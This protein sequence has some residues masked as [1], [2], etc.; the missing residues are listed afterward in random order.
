M[1]SK[2]ERATYICLIT[3]LIVAL[4]IVV[5][6]TLRHR[7]LSGAA[8]TGAELTGQHL[9]V[10]GLTWK[11]SALN[12]VLFVSPKCRFCEESTPFYRKITS[13]SAN[14]TKR[15]VVSALS[16]DS[17]EVVKESLSRHQVDVDG[18]YR[19]PR[20]N[21]LSVTPILLLVD[22][23]GVIRRVFHGKLDSSQEQDVLRVVAVGAAGKLRM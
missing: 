18:V 8:G 16:Y 5:E 7:Y 13:I 9:T 23:N 21:G 14:G 3:V 2:L 22:G 19:A 10:P 4:A 12:V 1:T 20:I 15:V 11:S 6:G 17:P